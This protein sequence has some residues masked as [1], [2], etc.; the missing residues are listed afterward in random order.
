MADVSLFNRMVEAGGDAYDRVALNRLIAAANDIARVL[1]EDGVSAG[2]RDDAAALNTVFRAALPLAIP[3]LYVEPGWYASAAE[4]LRRSAIPKAMEA[5]DSSPAPYTAFETFPEQ[6][7]KL[8]TLVGSASRLERPA[9]IASARLAQVISKA[10]AHTARRLAERALKWGTAASRGR[11]KNLSP[12]VRQKQQIAP[13]DETKFHAEYQAWYDAQG[14]KFE[15]TKRNRRIFGLRPSA[16]QEVA[17]AV[18]QPQQGG[19]LNPE[20]VGPAPAT[21]LTDALKKKLTAF[22]TDA[23]SDDEV[24]DPADES[25]NVSGLAGLGA[26]GFTPARRTFWDFRAPAEPTLRAGDGLRG[27]PDARRFLAGLGR[28]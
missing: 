26:L 10:L 1:E 4:V 13:A 16:A 2:D 28:F 23:P 20:K 5:A 27:V 24:A 7:D 12:Q 17:A 9:R 18:T 15:R 21:P 3:V 11:V 6:L 19:F 8:S 14:S 25:G 22:D